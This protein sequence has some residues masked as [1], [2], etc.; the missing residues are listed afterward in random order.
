MVAAEQRHQPLQLRVEAVLDALARGFVRIGAIHRA[1]LLVDGAIEIEKLGRAGVFQAIIIDREVPAIAEFLAYGGEDIL[2]GGVPVGP[3]RRRRLRARQVGERAVAVEGGQRAPGRAARLGILVADA[4]PHQRAVGQVGVDHAIEHPLLAVLDVDIA[5]AFLIAT[6]DAGADATVGGQRTGDIGG[7]APR[8]P[9]ADAG[10]R[11]A[12]EFGGV[13]MF[14]HQINRSGRIA[15]PRQQTGR[16]ADDFHPL[17]DRHVDAGFAIGARQRPGRRHAVD[18]RVADFEA[19]R[20]ECVAHIVIFVGRDAHRIGDDILHRDEILV[21][22]ALRG[23]DADRLGR[24]QRGE[25][26]ACRRVDLVGQRVGAGDDDRLFI[27][28]A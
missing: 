10:V 27:G 11:I 9:A 8:I 13:G 4:N 28:R 20:E 1:R 26:K 12:G 3:V 2:V 21:E 16:T 7:Q 17:V 6:D 23:H 25:A 14:A 15:R 19:A 22:N 5:F 18:L 24:F